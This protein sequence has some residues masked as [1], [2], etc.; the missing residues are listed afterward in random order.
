M[1]DSE[2]TGSA[3]SI[4]PTHRSGPLSA[5]VGRGNAHSIASYEAFLRDLPEL[6]QSHAGQ[7]AAYQDG[8]RWGV[9]PRRQ[10]F[11][12]EI[13]AQGADPQRMLFFTI[14]P[15]VPREIELLTPEW[16]IE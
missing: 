15:Q 4:P 8:V 9:G 14:E 13:Y 12:Q 16:E 6:M 10:P 11:F 1:I 3:G 5:S 2:V 7:C